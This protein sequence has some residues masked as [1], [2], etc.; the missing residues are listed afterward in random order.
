MER[1]ILSGIATKGGELSEEDATSAEE[2]IQS[3][4]T[5]KAVKLCEHIEMYT[6]NIE[7]CKDAFFLGEMSDT[8]NPC[9][10]IDSA[11]VT[12]YNVYRESPVQVKSRGK[13]NKWSG[14]NGEQTRKMEMYKCDNDKHHSVRGKEETCSIAKA[15]E[16][17][18]L[19]QL[20]EQRKRALSYVNELYCAKGHSI[21]N[22]LIEIFS[23]SNNDDILLYILQKFL[24]IHGLCLPCYKHG[25]KKNGCNLSIRCKWCH[26]YTHLNKNSPLYPSK[27]LHFKNKC[28]V[29]NHF[30]KGRFC[31][32]LNDCQFCH[33]V[34]HLPQIL[35]T[36]YFHTLK[37]LYENK[38]HLDVISK[39]L[40]DHLEQ[41]TNEKK[42]TSNQF[43]FID[44][45]LMNI[46][47]DTVTNQ[48]EY[49]ATSN[50][51]FSNRVNISNR[52]V[53]NK[54]KT[55]DVCNDCTTHK[56]RPCITYFLHER[57]CPSN[58]NNCHNDIHKKKNSSIY[59]KTYLHD[60]NMCYVCPFIN[61]V[62]CPCDDS[63]IYCH[64]TDHISYN[65]KAK[66]VIDKY[67]TSLHNEF[68][69]TR[70]RKRCSSNVAGRE[71]SSKRSRD[72]ST[73]DSRDY[74]PR[75][76]SDY[77]THGSCNN[78][79]EKL[80]H[81]GDGRRRRRRTLYHPLHSTREKEILH[82]KR[83]KHDEYDNKRKHTH[84]RSQSIHGEEGKNYSDRTRRHS[85]YYEENTMHVAIKEKGNIIQS[86]TPEGG[87]DNHGN[88][89]ESCDDL[90]DV[91]NG[92]SLNRLNTTCGRE[93]GIGAFCDTSAETF[94]NVV[95]AGDVDGPREILHD[96][97]QG[98]YSEEG[99]CGHE[100]DVPGKGVTNGR[101]KEELIWKIKG[102]IPLRDN[103]N[104][105]PYISV[106]P[107][108]SKE[109]I[110]IVELNESNSF[111]GKIEKQYENCSSP[112]ANDEKDTG[113]YVSQDKQ[114]EQN[115]ITHTS[116]KKNAVD[117]FDTKI[118]A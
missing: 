68:S 15:C 44:K 27:M 28:K 117:F 78:P 60:N 111:V 61:E 11:Q 13:H 3:K 32:L 106:E 115:S 12:G 97:A 59:I 34:E 16:L 99:E 83:R 89:R 116:Q 17:K 76:G 2:H 101:E 31:F 109:L 49:T 93:Q 75:D 30:V 7:T 1:Q 98:G 65:L 64:D 62:K 18:E 66:N 87:G 104:E 81:P 52:N 63:A 69:H 38:L 95:S 72:Y 48:E 23:L 86:H 54:K 77:S 58:C 57:D 103:H 20:G 82:K 53:Y 37:N 96:K 85:Y 6:D 118:N 46:C 102:D 8:V 50:D 43:D 73:R 113:N 88:T 67:A 110:T 10:E 80:Q 105:E 29:C 45:D 36:K 25:N 42:N 74:S 39:D 9:R 19:S 22:S 21:T 26:H 92:E 79:E 107:A 5:R 100:N 114:Y 56:K 55:F 94:A 90:C 70:E 108:G 35:K 4:E 33:S 112:F 84:S 51:N 14:Q 71:D 47:Q 40:L 91:Q 24:H 41:C